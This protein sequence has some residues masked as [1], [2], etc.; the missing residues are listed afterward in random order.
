MRTTLG[1]TATTWPGRSFQ[2]HLIVGEGVAFGLANEA[3]AYILANEAVAGR[4]EL[5]T[6]IGRA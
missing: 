6:E 1:L 4:L 2:S 3:V 5:Q